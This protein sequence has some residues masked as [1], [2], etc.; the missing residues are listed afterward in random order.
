[1]MV[2]IFFMAAFVYVLFSVAYINATIDDRKKEQQYNDWL[3]RYSRRN[4]MYDIYKR[5]GRR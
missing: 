2:A 4:S 3:F 1:M 5:G